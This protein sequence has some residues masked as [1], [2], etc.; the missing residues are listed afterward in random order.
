MVT[1]CFGKFG[2]W[3]VLVVMCVALWSA[4]GMKAA[5]DPPK[6]DVSSKLATEQQVLNIIAPS[7]GAKNMCLIDP[8][9]WCNAEDLLG[10][11]VVLSGSPSIPAETQRFC[12]RKKDATF[13]PSTDEGADVYSNTV[14]DDTAVSASLLDWIGVSKTK[15]D[16][17]QVKVSRAR[18][19]AMSVDFLDEDSIKA[20]LGNLDQK[21][22]AGLAIITGVVPYQ[23]SASVCRKEDRT[24]KSGVWYIRVNKNW[25]SK[26]E[27]EVK[28]N[29]LVAVTTP[30]T[31]IEEGLE[32][33][34]SIKS[35]DGFGNRSE[36]S[37]QQSVKVWTK[38]TGG[39]KLDK[40]LKP[41]HIVF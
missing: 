18:G 3:T 9:Q 25:Y 1:R 31:F 8:Q 35:I 41:Q 11:L 23:A 29:Y 7:S 37:L 13:K 27:Q 15:T 10:R 22:R 34:F 36:K 12:F 26:N 2:R 24:A 40:P 32:S 33:E 19:V 14:E 39:P 30:V 38:K 28:R 21:T 20:K 16:I 5:A 17:V 4:L 6:D